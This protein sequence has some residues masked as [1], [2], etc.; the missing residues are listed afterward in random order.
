MAHQV[1]W[2]ESI[3]EEFIQKAA[4]T[5]E[6]E[7]VMRTRVAGWTRTRQAMELQISIPTLDRI[8]ARLKV[9]YDA[10]QKENPDSFPPRRF[11]A[12]ELYMDTH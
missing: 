4:L 2:S 3:L 10:I 11:S 8:I 7:K 1:L 6:E 5:E 9:K 12:K